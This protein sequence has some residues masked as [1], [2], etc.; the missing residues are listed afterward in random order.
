MHAA[1]DNLDKAHT[2]IKEAVM[3]ILRPREAERLWILAERLGK[4]AVE[5][6]AGR[7]NAGLRLPLIDPRNGAAAMGSSK[8]EKKLVALAKAREVLAA[9]RRLSAEERMIRRRVARFSSKPL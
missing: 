2:H 8:S 3:H 4:I 1:A 9:K 6:R 5:F 7:R